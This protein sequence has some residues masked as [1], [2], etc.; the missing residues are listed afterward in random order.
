[1]Y[2]RYESNLIFSKHTVVLNLYA[3]N[4]TVS[5]YMTKYFQNYKIHN[6]GQ[7]FLTHICQEMIGQTFIKPNKMDT[8]LARLIKRK[9]NKAF[10]NLK[11]LSTQIL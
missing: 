9:R 4:K 8:F 11:G 7:T 10:R 3:H 2:L 6:L 1:M 5:K